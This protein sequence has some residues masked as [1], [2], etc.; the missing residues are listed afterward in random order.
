MKIAIAGA[1]GAVGQHLV[2]IAAAAGHEV[3]PLTRSSGDDLYRPSGLERRLHGV[4][5]VV[6]VS[7]TSSLSA[8]ASRAFFSTVTENLLAAERVAGVEHHIAL[9][10]VGAAAAPSGYYAGKALQEQIVARSGAR[11][12]MLRTTQFHEFAMQTVHRGA[13]LGAFIAPNLRSQPLAAADAAA[14]LLRIA[15]GAPCGLV[16]DLAGPREEFM[17]DLVRRYARATGRRNPVVSVTL[18]GASG[19]AMR[20]GGLLAQHDARRTTETFEHWLERIVA[21]THRR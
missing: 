6:D 11:W 20:T 8:R 4:D 1:T 12:S 15:E 3:L 14:E 19:R 21:E 7:G 18:P 2:A 9:S 10:I 16:P 5:S 13:M 17:P